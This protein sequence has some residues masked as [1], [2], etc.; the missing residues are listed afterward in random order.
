M[1]I[2]PELSSDDDEDLPSLMYAWVASVR[3]RYDRVEFMGPFN[4]R[5]VL[6]RFWIGQLSRVTR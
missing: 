2:S 4:P 3:R 1:S 5:L 6:T